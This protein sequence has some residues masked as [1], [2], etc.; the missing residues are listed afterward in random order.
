[1]ARAVVSDANGDVVCSRSL[2]FG[3][4]PDQQAVCRIDESIGW[5]TGIRE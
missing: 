5:R 2:R 4:R 1:M 3:R